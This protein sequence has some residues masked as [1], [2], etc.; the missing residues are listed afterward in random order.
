MYRSAEAVYRLSQ[1]SEKVRHFRSC[2]IVQALVIVGDVHQWK[3]TE[4]GES[5]VCAAAASG[6]GVR[7]GVGAGGH[8]P[9]PHAFVHDREQTTCALDDHNIKDVKF[10]TSRVN[11]R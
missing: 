8:W 3:A 5:V 1:P 6:E 11:K 9:E 4:T 10:Y 7:N 2:V